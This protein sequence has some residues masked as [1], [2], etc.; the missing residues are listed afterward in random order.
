M[1]KR[2]KKI[3]ANPKFAKLVRVRQRF[4]WSLTL[5]VLGC[6]FSYLM[7]G[8]ISP[9]WLTV[10]IREGSLITIGYP[11]SAAIVVLA[12]LA[13]GIYTH[14]ANSEFDALCEEILEEANK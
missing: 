4:A 6:F 5:L 3:Y 2:Q 7:I 11:I 13:T 1:D 10:P 8:M 9:D 14:R 12:W